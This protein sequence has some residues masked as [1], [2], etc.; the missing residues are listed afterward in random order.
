MFTRYNGITL[1]QNYSGN[2]FKAYPNDTETKT[3]KPQEMLPLAQN[4][5]TSVSPSFRDVTRE[6]PVQD[7][8][9]EEIYEEPLFDDEENT[10]LREENEEIIHTPPREN[11]CEASNEAP[12]PVGKIGLEHLFGNL[13]SDDILLLTLIFILAKDSSAQSPDAILI[14]ALL[15]FLH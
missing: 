4:V 9:P 5:R 2:R 12:H 7:D 10:P 1:P 15:L 13:Q 8:F 14:L 11:Q 3:H 6:T